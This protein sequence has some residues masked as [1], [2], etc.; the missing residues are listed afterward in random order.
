MKLLSS[1][2]VLVISGIVSPVV[3][4]GQQS[5][6]MGW[7]QKARPD[8]VTPHNVKAHFNH[9]HLNIRPPVRV[10]IETTNNLLASQED[11]PVILAAAPSSTATDAG[12]A[13]SAPATAATQQTKY[14]AVYSVCGYMHSADQVPYNIER[15]NGVSPM[16][17]IYEYLFEHGVTTST[18]KTLSPQVRALKEPSHGKLAP[19]TDAGVSFIYHAEQGYLG[20]DQM[21]FEVEVLGKKFK[22]IQTVVVH[23][24]GN[25]D[26]PT[27]AAQKELYRLCPSYNRSS[28]DIIELPTGGLASDEE[29][30]NLHSMVSFA[31]GAG[32]LSNGALN[33]ADLAGSALGHH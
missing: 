22:V 19:Y 32:G 20:S 21:I 1:L 15:D 17:P 13:A 24:S 28:L 2:L 29:L 30:A 16:T 14:D 10:D 12:A 18:F 4:A 33:I 11:Q 31:L 5:E 6:G 27:G 7:G 3:A 9:F 25:P 8:P 26:F 23:N